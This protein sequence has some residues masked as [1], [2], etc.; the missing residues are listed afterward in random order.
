MSAIK[1]TRGPV[2]KTHSQSVELTGA[3]DVLRA[4][5]AYRIFRVD[6]HTSWTVGQEDEGKTAAALHVREIF[7]SPGSDHVSRFKQVLRPEQLTETPDWLMH[8]L[9]YACPRDVG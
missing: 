8:I 1:D 5:V 3:A 7:G 2:K 9:I 4:G 6:V